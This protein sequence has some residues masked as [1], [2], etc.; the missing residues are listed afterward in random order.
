MVAFLPDY[1][2]QLHKHWITYE[3]VSTTEQRINLVVKF[4]KL[5]VDEKS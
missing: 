2:E 3:L 1:V 4:V 5:K